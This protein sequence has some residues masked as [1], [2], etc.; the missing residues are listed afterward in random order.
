MFY[1]IKARLKVWLQ[2]KNSPHQINQL[3]EHKGVESSAPFNL[4]VKRIKLLSYNVQ[5]GISTSSYR[6]YVT[7]SWQHILPHSKRLEN[8][9]KIAT[10]LQRYDVVALQE[11]DGGSIRSGYVN[12]VQYLAEA[13]GFPFWFQQLNRNLG[14]LAQH[15]NGLLSRFR[16]FEVT[17]H[18][19]PGVVPGRG[20]IVAKY[21]K[22][23]NPLVLV[24][25]HLSLSQEGQQRQLNFVRELVSGYRHVVLMGDLN[26]QLD[27]LL[28]SS[29]L[30]DMSLNLLRGDAFTFPSWRPVKGLDHILVSDSLKVIRSGVVS[31][32]MSDHLPI[33]LELEL[34]KDY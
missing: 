33:A 24:I 28:V 20:A 30:K 26:C 15:S 23:S 4:P 1:R 25:T 9:N 32:P 17:E 2:S 10:L 27:A 12:Q 19:L 21:G 5:V 7:R 31:F 29:P 18:K 13:S 6:H 14:R 8:L 22:P 11:V 34:P 3:Q 16:P